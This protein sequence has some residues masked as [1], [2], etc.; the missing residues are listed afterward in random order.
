MLTHMVMELKSRYCLSSASQKCTPLARFT[1]IGFTFACAD[2]VK[3]T[4]SLVRGRISSSARSNMLFLYKTRL[5]GYI[6]SST[7][8]ATKQ[9][10]TL[11]NF[12][13]RDKLQPV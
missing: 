5:S 3:K 9:I 2:Q 10:I 4:C 7:A 12:G 6:N 8:D 1:A 13:F 11:P